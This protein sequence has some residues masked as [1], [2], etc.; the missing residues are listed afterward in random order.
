VR[1]RRVLLCAA[2]LVLILGWAGS[3]IGD[4]FFFRPDQAD[5]GALAQTTNAEQVAFS[6]PGGPRLHGVWLE[7][8]GPAAGTVVYCHG[9]VAN[10]TEHTRFVTWLPARGFQVLLFDYR[11]YGRSEGSPDRPGAVADAI[12]AIDFALQRDPRRTVVFGHSLGGALGLLA[13]AERPAVRAV[14]IESS[15]AS[16]R[17]AARCTMPALGFLMSWA[18]SCELEPMSA[19]DRIPPRPLM[20]SHGSEDRIVPLELGRELFAAAREPKQWYLAEGCGHETPWLR[21]GRHFEEQVVA[22]FT[23]ALAR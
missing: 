1:R 21:Q 5:H 2:A 13:A 17:A 14:L 23:Q 9:S 4:R 22:F 15:F 12:A 18:V 3:G 7:A 11:G 16:W 10:L 20:V 19:L 6:A 8:K